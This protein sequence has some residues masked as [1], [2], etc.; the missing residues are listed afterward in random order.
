MA[1]FDW[2]STSG[3]VISGVVCLVLSDVITTA[4][5]LSAGQ[6]EG[7]KGFAF[8]RFT[9]TGLAALRCDGSGLPAGVNSV[10]HITLF[11]HPLGS[12]EP[13]IILAQLAREDGARLMPGLTEHSQVYVGGVLDHVTSSALTVILPVKSLESSV[14]YACQI[15]YVPEGSRPVKTVLRLN[16]SRTDLQP[17]TTPGTPRQTPGYDVSTETLPDTRH[18]NISA[19]RTQPSR[20]TSRSP[21]DWSLNTTTAALMAMAVLFIV[22][23][24]VC[25]VLVVDRCSDTAP[26]DIQKTLGSLPPPQPHSC[27]PSYTPGISRHSKQLAKHIYSDD[28]ASGYESDGS[29]YYSQPCDSLAQGEATH[30]EKRSLKQGEASQ[31]RRSLKQ[32]EA[33]QE[34]RSLRPKGRESSSSYGLSK[35]EMNS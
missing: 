23:C 28:G 18:Y 19:E 12:R 35:P 27:P 6:E 2:T 22:L 21:E 3:W 9:S 34:K 32:G 25:V 16:V 31:E 33:S 1:A 8:G 11:K 7:D 20:G 26:G 17:T 5:D 10:N 15:D 24:I 4:A 13:E 30:Q 14:T 29:V